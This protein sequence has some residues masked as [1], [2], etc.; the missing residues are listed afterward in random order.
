M[1]LETAW[2]ARIL[3]QLSRKHSLHFFLSLVCSLLLEHNGEQ[4]LL[5][6]I[7]SETRIAASVLRSYNGGVYGC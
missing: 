3:A 4:E 1:L 7:R 2:P 5:V 6:V